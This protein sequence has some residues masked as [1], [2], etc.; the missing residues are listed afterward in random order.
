[1]TRAAFGGTFAVTVLADTAAE[2]PFGGGVSGIEL[3]P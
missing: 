2:V 1:M 3:P